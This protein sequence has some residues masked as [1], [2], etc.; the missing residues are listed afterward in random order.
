MQGSVLPQKR[1]M[2]GYGFLK[3]ALGKG[4]VF[5]RWVAHTYQVSA[6]PQM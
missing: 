4:M 6:P 1:P 5:R 3:I 2:Q